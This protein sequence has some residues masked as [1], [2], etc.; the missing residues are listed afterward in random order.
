MLNAGKYIVNAGSRKFAA[1]TL[2]EVIVSMLLTA[3]LLTTASVIYMILSRQFQA[4]EAKN[5]FYSDYYTTHKMIDSELE[6]AFFV[7]AGDSENT[8]ELQMKRRDANND[9]I[10]YEMYQD[11]ILR[12]KGER[13]DTLQPGGIITAFKTLSDTLPLITQIKIEYRYQQLIFF[14]NHKKNYAAEQILTY[15][16]HDQA[17]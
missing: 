5:R 11:Y 14:A 6:K 1:F 13:T 2:P 17:H 7:L 12:T 16:N 9:P 10:F 15:T 3:I 8:I 4:T